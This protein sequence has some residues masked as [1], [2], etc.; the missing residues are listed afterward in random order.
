MKSIKNF[1]SKVNFGQELHD[2]RKGWYVKIITDEVTGIGEAAPIPSIS[3]EC[4]S[5][6]GYALDGFSLA[7]ERY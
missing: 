1:I 2:I 4:H 5:Q 7:L 3:T 6:Y